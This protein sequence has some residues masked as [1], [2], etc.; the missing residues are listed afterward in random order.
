MSLLWG[1]ITDFFTYETTKS[2]VVKSWSVG[3]INRVVQLLII[4]YF[5]WSVEL[6]CVC[7]CVCVC[8]RACVRACVYDNVDLS[9]SSF[10]PPE[11]FLLIIL[12]LL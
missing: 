1:F 2:V 4:I 3:I 9:L 8:V 10:F 12:E 5:V 11:V 7:V 6:V